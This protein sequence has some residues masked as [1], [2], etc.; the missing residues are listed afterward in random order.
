[1]GEE[2]EVVGRILFK[3]LCGFKYNQHG[4]PMNQLVNEFDR[5]F[6]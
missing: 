1:M 6:V 5:R 3:L 4:K 2:E